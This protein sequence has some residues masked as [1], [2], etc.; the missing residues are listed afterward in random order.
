ML[1]DVLD[2]GLSIVFCGTA[3]G[4]KSAARQQYYAG[5]GN[6]FWHILFETDL[7][8]D[9]L[10]P[11]LYRSVLHYKLGLTDLVKGKS[12]MDRTLKKTDYDHA[13]FREKI[14]H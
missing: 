11:I 1:P 3:A 4:D 2:H 13:A 6:K 9:K 7:T 14:L 10:H 8:K 5:D 12:G